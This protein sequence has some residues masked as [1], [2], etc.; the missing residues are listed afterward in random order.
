MRISENKSKRLR[1]SVGEYK[2]CS[3]DTSNIYYKFLRLNY[4]N[5]ID[6]A[7]GL[8]RGLITQKEYNELKFE[9]YYAECPT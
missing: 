4:P 6:D 5:L 8:R 9:Y 3:I 1:S 2:I 7:E